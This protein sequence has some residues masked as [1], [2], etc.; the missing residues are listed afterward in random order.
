MHEAL[1]ISTLYASAAHLPSLTTILISVPVLGF[2]LF[3]GSRSAFQSHAKNRAAG[4][5]LTGQTDDKGVPLF[6]DVDSNDDA[7]TS[8]RDAC[9]THLRRR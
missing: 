4:R 3:V 8:A 1:M 9:R 6:F 5:V 7:F 2:L